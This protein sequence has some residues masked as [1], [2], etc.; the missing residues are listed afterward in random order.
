MRLLIVSGLSGSGKTVALHTLED[1]GY[2]CVDNLPLPLLQDLIEQVRN[3]HYDTEGDR[4]LAVGVDVRSGL[5]ALRGFGDL[6]RVLRADGHQVEVLFL[7]AA[8]EVLLRRYHLTRRRH[9][10]ARD[11][12]PLVE[13]IEHERKWLGHVAAE[14]DLTVDTSRLSMHDLARTLRDRMGGHGE[15]ELSLLFQSFGFKHGAPMDSDFVFDVRCLPNPHYERALSSLTG[16]DQPV[17]DFL[18]RHTEVAA[19]FGSIQGYLEQWLPR[20]LEDHRSYVTVSIGCTGGR[21]RSVYL[22]ER[23][24]EAWRGREH[25]T[26]SIRH[27][28]LGKQ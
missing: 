4:H 17:C 15:H 26:V 24:A 25:V 6:L 21:H 2:F 8:S 1:A 7:Q 20:L 18:D 28:E 16:R 13:A 9:P 10:L 11:G 12:L 3:G 14:A 23:L 5:E 19:M 22:V 27:R